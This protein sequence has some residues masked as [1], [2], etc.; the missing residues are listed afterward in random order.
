MYPECSIAV[1]GG[2]ARASLHRSGLLALYM[3]DAL[4]NQPA[5][6]CLLTQLRR[7]LSCCHSPAG[8][9]SSDGCLGLVVWHPQLIQ[10][11]L[12]RQ[13]GASSNSEAVCHAL[14]ATM[15]LANQ[16]RG[17]A[18]ELQGKA[19]VAPENAQSHSQSRRDEAPAREQF[20][21]ASPTCSGSPSA[22]ECLRMLRTGT[23]PA[24]PCIQQQPPCCRVTEL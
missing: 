17:V 1:Y 9:Q 20:S 5:S 22:H 15:A 24:P 23:P 13:Q 2:W 7:I 4:P 3:Q 19:L 8:P 12:Q 21:G 10:R 6:F 11:R 18:K 14:A 16:T